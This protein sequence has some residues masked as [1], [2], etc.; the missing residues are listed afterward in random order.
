MVPAY[1]NACNA[2]LMT[3]LIEGSPNVVKEALA[4]NAN[5]IA[6]P[7]GDA[8]EMLEGVQNCQRVSRQPEQIAAALCD[9]L[10]N[11][12][13]SNGR[14]RLQERRLSL[15]GVAQQVL[16]VYRQALAPLVERKSNLPTASRK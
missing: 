11:N 16:E 7:V 14:L 6:V 2:M 1:M 10:Q 5:V 12:E 15:D 3:S 13:L 9:V 8:H 4:C